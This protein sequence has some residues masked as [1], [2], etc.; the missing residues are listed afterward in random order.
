MTLTKTLL[1][2]E[3]VLAPGYKGRA[4]FMFF[5]E[6]CQVRRSHLADFEKQLSPILVGKWHYS[7]LSLRAA[8]IHCV[9]KKRAT[10]YCDDNY[11][12]S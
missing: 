6:N 12:K 8:Y 5:A 1:F 3:H 10:L 4:K 11:V 7:V 9:S 2:I